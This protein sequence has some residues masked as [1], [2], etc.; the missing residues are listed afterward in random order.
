MHSRPRFRAAQFGK[1]YTVFRTRLGS[2]QREE[3]AQVKLRPE[4][5]PSPSWIHDFPCEINLLA[6]VW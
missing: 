2:D 5:F 4:I 1:H 3:I 6:P